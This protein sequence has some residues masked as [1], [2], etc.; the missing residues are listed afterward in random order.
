MK[1]GAG[2][3]NPPQKLSPE[4]DLSRFDSGEPMLDG[5]LRR[6]AQRN[7]TSG[8]SR[9]YVVCAARKVVVGY[10]SLAVGA[11][12]HVDAPGRV[13]RNMPDPVPVMVLGRLAVDQAF[14]GRGVGTGLL[15]DAVLRTLQAAEIAG[16]RA[17]LVHAIS[18][19]AKR[20]YEKYGFVASPIDSL[21]VMIT[22]AEAF[23]MLGYGASKDA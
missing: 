6:H 13:R 1:S 9:T 10:Y 16:I 17:I 21:T 19:N 7:E 8:A 22:V 2:E 20:F 11:V 15:R 14:H 4:H 18:E 12:A 23:K 3:I 5:W